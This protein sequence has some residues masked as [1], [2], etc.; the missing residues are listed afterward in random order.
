VVAPCT[1]WPEPSCTPSEMPS[2][3]GG[4]RREDPAER[5][6]RNAE[7]TVPAG[8]DGASRV[9]ADADARTVQVHA[10]VVHSGVTRSAIRH[11]CVAAQHRWRCIDETRK[12]HAA[13][14]RHDE[15][16]A[17]LVPFLL[18]RRIVAATAEKAQG[19]RRRRRTDLPSLVPG[20]SWPC[21]A[22]LV[23]LAAAKK[24]NR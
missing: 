8:R 24:G 11:P 1:D 3:S 6:H 20:V 15:A 2:L 5:R 9:G 12:R 19:P 13:V 18:L 23:L 14:V 21:V 17:L 4:I 22:R 16:D 7:R 10:L